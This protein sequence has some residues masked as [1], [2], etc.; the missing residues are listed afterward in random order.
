MASTMET[1]AAEIKA[2]E[3]LIVGLE[4]GSIKREDKPALE[5]HCRAMLERKKK[6]AAVVTERR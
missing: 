1:I 6:A 5:H 2:L 4:G 3:K